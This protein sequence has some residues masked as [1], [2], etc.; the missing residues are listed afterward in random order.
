VRK[1]LVLSALMEI[2]LPEIGSLLYCPSDLQMRFVYCSPS[3]LYLSA[4]F[5]TFWLFV[6][7]KGFLGFKSSKCVKLIKHN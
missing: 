1:G 3:W 6:G 2:H 4:V 5:L 7:S